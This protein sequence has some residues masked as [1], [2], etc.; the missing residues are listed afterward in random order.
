MKK[1]LNQAIKA[2]FSSDNFY[3]YH[4]PPDMMQWET[5][6]TFEYILEI[7]FFS[8]QSEIYLNT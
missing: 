8:F 2:N 6:S 4:I 7:Y 1:H 3:W 5:H